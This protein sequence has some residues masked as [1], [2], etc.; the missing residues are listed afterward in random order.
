MRRFMII[1][2]II[3]AFS[4][5]HYTGGPAPTAADY[6]EVLKLRAELQEREAEYNKLWDLYV[7]QCASN[8]TMYRML[9]P[10]EE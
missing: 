6:S 1:L 8:W 5:G 10:G 9:F 7:D 3:L 4:F 2:I